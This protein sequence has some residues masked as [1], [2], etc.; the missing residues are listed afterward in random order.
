VSLKPVS[1][2]NSWPIACFCIFPHQFKSTRRRA[3]A[4]IA[5]SELAIRVKFKN[6]AVS[7]EKYFAPAAWLA[8][9]MSASVI[10]SP[11]Q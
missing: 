9:Q 3:K 11:W 5:E 2:V 4:S 6:G 8:R 10:A 1:S 7:T